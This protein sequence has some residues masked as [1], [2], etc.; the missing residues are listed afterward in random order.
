MSGTNSFSAVTFEREPYI[1][2][3]SS[4]CSDT[5]LHFVSGYESVGVKIGIIE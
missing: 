2:F 5:L 4:S 1:P 3:S